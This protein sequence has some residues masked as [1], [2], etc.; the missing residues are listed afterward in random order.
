MTAFDDFL[1]LLDQE[2][3]FYQSMDTPPLRERV[4]CW[5]FRLTPWQDRMI[6]RLESIYRLAGVLAIRAEENAPRI[7][8]KGLL[9]ALARL[10]HQEWMEWS[11]AIAENECLSLNRMRRW[12]GDLWK[13]YDELTDDQKEQDRERARRMLEIVEDYY[14]AA[15]GE[16]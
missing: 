16:G 9:E 12:Q 1:E 11:K 7:D 8:R 2:I 15:R 5:I 4:Y 6:R 13:P 3:G 10:S 14:R